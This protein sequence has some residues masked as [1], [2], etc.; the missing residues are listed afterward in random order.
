MIDPDKAPLVY[1]L[2]VTLT[3]PQCDSPCHMLAPS[4]I[5]PLHPLEDV[6]STA[7]LEA[8]MRHQTY[9]C[10]QGEIMSGPI[11]PPVDQK[12]LEYYPKNFETIPPPPPDLKPEYLEGKRVD[13]NLGKLGPNI[14]TIH[15]AIGIH[16]TDNNTTTAENIIKAVEYAHTL[17]EEQKALSLRLLELWA[18]RPTYI[19]NNRIT[20]DGVQQQEKP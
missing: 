11:H 8:Y 17:P 6:I 18:S 4:T 3:C 9:G 7:I 14:A 12:P 20:I 15:K 2:K 10:P 5:M 13:L 1:G 16:F 19:S